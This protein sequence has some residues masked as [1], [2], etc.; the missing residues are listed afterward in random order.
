MRLPWQGS[1]RAILFA[2]GQ[3]SRWVAK[4]LCLRELLPGEDVVQYW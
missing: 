2:A 3:S 1:A 4:A